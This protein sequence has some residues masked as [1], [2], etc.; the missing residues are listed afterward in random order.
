MDRRKFVF[1]GAAGLAATAFSLR[2][3]AANPVCALHYR[4]RD[5]GLDDA[6]H[7]AI[8]DFADKG[9]AAVAFTPN[10]NGW[11]VV[12]TRGRVRSSGIPAACRTKIDDFLA[13]GK[14]INSI[15]FPPGRTDGWVVVHEMG[16]ASRNIPD[17]CRDE[18]ER[19]IR[20]EEREVLCV[21]FSSNDG[22]CIVGPNFL[23]YSRVPTALY[24]RLDALKS[25]KV[26]ESRHRAGTTVGR[27]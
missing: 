18:L 1:F 6:A 8:V 26:L 3:S 4:L 10:G 7:D 25:G 17:V 14:K 23:R 24:N 9:I 19:Y 16:F 2:A 20:T 12:S 13:A 21:A 5:R 11:V 27:S 22:F 15:A